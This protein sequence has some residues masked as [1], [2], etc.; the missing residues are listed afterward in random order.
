MVFLG[1]LEQSRYLNSGFEELTLLLL[2]GNNYSD[3][4]SFN[5]PVS[6]IGSVPLNNGGYTFSHT[7]DN[8]LEIPNS[9]VFDIGTDYFYIQFD[10]H[11]LSGY[12]DIN[13]INKFGASGDRSFRTRL[14]NSSILI[15]VDGLG[16]RSSLSFS[17]PDF[18]TSFQTFKIE[19]LPS[20]TQPTRNDAFLFYYKNQL[21]SFREISRN[22]PVLSTTTPLRVGRQ[23]YGNKYASEFALK[24]IM[25]VKYI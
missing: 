25:F 6:V 23:E 7:G 4:S 24:N 17:D 5:H 1:V 20:P 12:R 14:F 13:F 21:I 9:P 8:Y 15:A 10:L 11:F 3:S 18:L 2:L 22:I 16:I 19:K